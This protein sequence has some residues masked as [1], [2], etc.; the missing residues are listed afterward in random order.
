MT[1]IEISELV[2]EQPGFDQK[3][4]SESQLRHRIQAMN[5]SPEVAAMQGLTIE[6]PA[7]HREL[8]LPVT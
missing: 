5:A 8:L 6:Y 7:N 2:V 1:E 4:G 3:A